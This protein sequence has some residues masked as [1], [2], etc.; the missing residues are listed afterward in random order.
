M[1]IARCDSKRTAIMHKKHRPV[2][3]SGRFPFRGF[4]LQMP[5]KDRDF[6]VTFR[7]LVMSAGPLC[8][9]GVTGAST[10]SSETASSEPPSADLGLGFLPS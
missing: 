5:T 1:Q 4:C 8:F 10:Q 2:T 3:D 6:Q 9:S 7:L